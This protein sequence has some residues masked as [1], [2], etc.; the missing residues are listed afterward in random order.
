LS[1]KIEKILAKNPVVK[2]TKITDVVQ[3]DSRERM[4][5]LAMATECLDWG[6]E[7]FPERSIYSFFKTC[8]VCLALQVSS[9][10]ASI[11]GKSE[12]RQRSD[13]L[14][15]VGYYPLLTGA[16]IPVRVFW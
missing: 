15:L 10:S 16:A 4:L 12:A 7:D 1:P 13:V 6:G 14:C 5:S 2:S 8:S 9:C 11:V 3:C